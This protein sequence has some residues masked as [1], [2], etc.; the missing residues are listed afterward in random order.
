VA[1][2]RGAPPPRS[3]LWIPMP[4]IVIVGGGISGLALAHRLQQRAADVDAIVLEERS[5]L[6]GVIDSQRRDG[7]LIETGPN[8]FLDNKPF[9]RSLCRELG[10]GDHLVAASEAARRNRY[11]FLDGRLRLLPNSLASFLTSDALSWRTRFLL[12]AECFRPPRRKDG[13][14]SIDAF[15]RRR[16]GPELAET[17]ADAFVTGIHAG[18][19]KLLSVAAALPRL[20]ELEREHGSVL[21]GMSRSARRRGEPPSPPRRMWSFRE[22]LKLLIDALAAQLRFVPL[23][24]VSVRTVRRVPDGSWRV[25]SDGREVWDADAVVLTCPADQQ[26]AILADEDADL[27]GAIDAIPYNRIAVVA[28]GY[29]VADVHGPLDGFGYLSPQ[30]QRRDVLGVQWCS[31]IFPERAP[32]GLVLLRALCGGWHRAEMLDWDDERLLNAVRGELRCAMGIRNAPVFHHVIRWRRA[33]PQYHLG[34]LD[35]VAWIENRLTRHPGL[36]LGGNGYRGIALNDCVE[37]AGL[38]AEKLMRYLQQRPAR[39]LSPFRRPCER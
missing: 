14:E 34:H 1:L 37:Q 35:R 2:N 15:V 4:R 8:G 32:P 16:V 30:R 18:D 23:T 28:L 12:L 3:P 24:G 11:V 36:F 31:S 38:L 10:L 20:A 29:R 25:Q 26:A 17:L 19:P 39:S 33:L 22:G 21:R 13:D 5:R 7:F 6:G 27:A 9:V